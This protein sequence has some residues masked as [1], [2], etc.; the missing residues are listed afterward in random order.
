MGEF[1]RNIDVQVKIQ[2]EKQLLEND[3]KDLESAIERSMAIVT[4][5][6]NAISILDD[7]LSVGREEQNNI[8]VELQPWEKEMIK[9]FETD[10]E[11]KEE[12]LKVA[13]EEQAEDIAKETIRT[14]KQRS[15]I[16]NAS[17]YWRMVSRR[18][19]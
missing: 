1:K 3:I 11:I 17:D 14:G 18:K 19:L 10:K 5:K 13:N 4:E 7:I 16:N 6:K 15:K 9:M 12:L 2:N 8:K